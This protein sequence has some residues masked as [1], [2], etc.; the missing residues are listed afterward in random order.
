MLALRDYQGVK[1][2][3][4]CRKMRQWVEAGS[5]NR[6]EIVETCAAS[7]RETETAHWLDRTAYLLPSRYFHFY[8][9]KERCT[10][11]TCWLPEGF[12]H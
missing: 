6:L 2:I 7:E 12:A 10:G 9:F 11:G 5:M 1:L 4:Q 3:A 8:L